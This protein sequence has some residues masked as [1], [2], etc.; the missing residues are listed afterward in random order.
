LTPM[1]FEIFDWNSLRPGDEIEV[2]DGGLVIA[3]GVIEDLASDS[4]IIRLRLSYGRSERTYRR[5]AGW[6]VRPICR[7]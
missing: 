5:E 2:L 3:R 7:V 1:S 4:S 6:Q